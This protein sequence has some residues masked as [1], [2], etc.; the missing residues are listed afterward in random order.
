MAKTVQSLIN[1]IRRRNDV[2]H[3]DDEE[4]LLYINELD[5][6]IAESLYPTF[7]SKVISLV[8]GTLRY[9][10]SDDTDP[11]RIEKV[12]IDGERI[13]KKRDAGDYLEGWYIDGNDIVLTED[14]DNSEAMVVVYK[15]KRTPHEIGDAVTDEN[16][17]IP[18]AYH[19]LYTFYALSQLAAK[20][21]DTAS[22]ASY[23]EDYNSLLSEAVK[24]TTQRQLFPNFIL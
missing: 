18:Q 11:N 9:D 20:E 3:V 19:D 14:L 5:D 7:D 23:K 16:L 2:S 6:Q 10:I 24:V 21:A 17:A 22:Y 1:E 8:G 13:F 15:R 12:F 4:L